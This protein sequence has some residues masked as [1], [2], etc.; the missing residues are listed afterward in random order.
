MSK[1]HGVNSLK[2]FEIQVQSLLGQVDEKIKH[3]SKKE[4]IRLLEFSLKFSI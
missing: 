2:A 1:P 4:A 3:L